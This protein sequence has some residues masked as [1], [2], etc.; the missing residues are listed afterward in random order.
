MIILNNIFY[1]GEW[2]YYS[3]Y[4]ILGRIST[5]IQGSSS[6]VLPWKKKKKTLSFLNAGCWSLHCFGTPCISRRRSLV[7][8]R[9]KT[10]TSME[11]F[12]PWVGGGVI[13]W[14]EVLEMCH[15]IGSHF[16]PS[17][18]WMTPSQTLILVN[19]WVVFFF[20]SLFSKSP[21]FWQI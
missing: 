18:K 10:S 15:G 6:V 7:C 8:T 1:K 4:Y 9:S 13:R 17:G 14:K 2:K 16:Q 12:T 19:L 3:K 20:K 11:R 5:S 21:K